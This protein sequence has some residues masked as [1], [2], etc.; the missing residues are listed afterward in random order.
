MSIT[1]LEEQIEFEITDDLKIDVNDFVLIE[2]CGKKKTVQ[3]V[4]KI[5]GIEENYKVNF[6]RRKQ[7]SWKFYFP[8]K[9]D[10]SSLERSDIKMKLPQPHLSEGP[11]QAVF[12]MTFSINFDLIKDKII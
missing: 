9:E 3:Y 1:S 8:E 12:A 4:G 6:M 2:F 11:A 7:D 10:I 5:E